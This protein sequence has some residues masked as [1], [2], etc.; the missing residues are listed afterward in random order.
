LIVPSGD[1]ERCIATATARLLDRYGFDA[2][3]IGVDVTAA[4]IIDL[5]QNIK[6]VLAVRLLAMYECGTIPRV[7]ERIVAVDRDGGIPAILTV[8]PKHITLSPGGP[9]A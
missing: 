1:V 4:E 3:D 9:Q 5:L 8:D 7:D 6:D 2:R